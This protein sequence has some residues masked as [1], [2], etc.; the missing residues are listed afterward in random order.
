[1]GYPGAMLGGA[2]TTWGIGRATSSDGVTWSVDASPT[3]DP[4][5]GSFWECAAVQPS[6]VYEGPGE[7]HLFFKAFQEA[8]K[9]CDDDTGNAD[10]IT[11]PEWGCSTVTGVGYASSTNGV[12]WTVQGTV[13]VVTPDKDP[14]PEDFRVATGR[15]GVRHVD[16]V[17]ELRRQRNHR[18]HGPDPAGPW[19]WEG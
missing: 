5:Q 13:P 18:R 7:W 9:T 3:L 4:S 14:S 12:D 17:H 10:G 6:V 2:G 11:D 19:D 15:A 8:G 1:M 16:D